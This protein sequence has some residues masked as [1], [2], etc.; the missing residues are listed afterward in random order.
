MKYLLLL[1]ISFSA[2]ANW[3]AESKIGDCSG[4]QRVFGNRLRCASVMGEN[5]V[6]LSSDYNCN[7]KRYGSHDVTDYSNPL[8]HSK[9]EVESCV[10]DPDCSMY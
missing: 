3:M 4:S 8:T 7:Y 10:D 5:C 1:L 9:S 6:S 2:N